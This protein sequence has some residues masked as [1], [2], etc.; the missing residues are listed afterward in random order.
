VVA[1]H[2][3]KLEVWSL[4]GA[5]DKGNTEFQV[6]RMAIDVIYSVVP[7]DMIATLAVKH[8]TKDAWGC[9]KTMCIGDDRV[10]KATLQKVRREYELLSFRDGESVEDFAM[11]HNLT[12]QLATLGDVEP[13]HKIIDKYLCI[14]RPRYKQLVISIE[15]MLD[16]THLSVEEI[17]S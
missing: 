12:T 6:D 7:V 3:E 5:V 4:W 15:T 9:I 16:S 11:R 10:C 8:T 2:E 13:D 1:A 17:T 14:A